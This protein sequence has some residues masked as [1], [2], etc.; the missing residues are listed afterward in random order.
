MPSSLP[1]QHDNGLHFLQQG[2]AQLSERCFKRAL[3]RN[4]RHLRT[5]VSYARLLREQNNTTQLNR[6]ELLVTQAL[7]V[8]QSYIPAVVSKIFS[9]HCVLLTVLSHRGLW[10]ACFA[11]GSG[12][13]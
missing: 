7:S 2:C 11:G 3:V 8:D 1:L 12:A 6:A 10:G 5:L 13:N 9:Y 4:P